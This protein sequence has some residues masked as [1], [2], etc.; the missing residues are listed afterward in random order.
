[1][2]QLF[3]TDPDP[4]CKGQ[5]YTVSYSGNRPVDITVSVDGDTPTEHTIGAENGISLECPENAVG[6]TIHD[7]SGVSNDLNIVPS[8]C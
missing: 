1:M 4:V 6:I 2:T 3:S 8:N 5:S 7:E